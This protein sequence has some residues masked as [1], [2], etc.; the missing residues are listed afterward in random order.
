M[1]DENSVKY[2]SPIGNTYLA[3][4]DGR[5]M[6]QAK[7]HRRFKLLFRYGNQ[8]KAKLMAQKMADWR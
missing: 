1:R 3:C 4:S 8:E 5:L 2:T 7:G 6:I